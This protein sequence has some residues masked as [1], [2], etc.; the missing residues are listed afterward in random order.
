MKFGAITN[1][2]RLQL[3]DQ[4]LI[5]LVEKAQS[6]AAQHVELRQTCL[7]ACETGENQEWRP[8]LPKLQAL[9]DAFPSMEF[10]LAM[11]LPCLTQRVEPMGEQFQ[12]ALE[13]A[14]LVG[15]SQPHLRLVDPAR[16]EGVWE[17][18]G[19]LPE[20]ALGMVELAREAARQGVVM[21]IEN[22]GQPIRSMALLVRQVQSALSA[23]ESAFLGLCPDPTNQ[24]GRFPGSDPLAELDEL[25]VDVIKIIHFKQARDGSPRPSVETGDLDCEKM[26]KMLERKGFQGPAIMEIPPHQQVFE[27]LSASFEYLGGLSSQ[28]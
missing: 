27:N 1:S 3:A 21:S 19:D 11:A 2:W 16:T 28:S 22:S 7:G 20:E 14:K 17:T 13:A 12:A 24:L 26:V 8:V 9:V 5:P 15:R 6:L 10:D 18:P 4:D 25:P 23:E